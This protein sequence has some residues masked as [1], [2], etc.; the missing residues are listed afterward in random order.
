MV[1][2]SV[3]S[4]A[5]GSK[6]DQLVRTAVRLFSE[7]GYHAT[8]IDR[9][10][11]EAGISKRTLYH[12]FRTK[13][14]LILAA[15]RHH[16]GVFRNDFVK[17][18]ERIGSTPR[19]RLLAI[20][21][22][23]RDWFCDTEFHGCMFINAIG[24]YSATDTAI[25]AACQEFKR[26]LRNYIRDQAIE[27]GTADPEALADE[28]ALLLEGAIATAQVSGVPDSAKLARRMAEVLVARSFDA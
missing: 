19:E 14:E 9:I 27:A 25:R 22:V 6:R 8:G 28:L 12:H 23:A 17:S 7:H 3:T 15:L 2:S 16:D 10:A 21:D 13:D 24:E 1:N 11:G 20:Y 4:R 26:L 18:V 5:K